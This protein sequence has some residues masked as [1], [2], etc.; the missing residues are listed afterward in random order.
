MPTGKRT[1]PSA[2]AQEISNILAHRAH[3]ARVTQAEL[4]KAADIS[5]SQLSKILR[6]DRQM[7]VDHLY[8]MCGA[9]GLKVR[10]VIREAEAVARARL[11]ASHGSGD[12]REPTALPFDLP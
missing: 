5:Q 11:S 3:A 6:G 12:E 9:L 10:D 2:V 1:K 4:A 8:A 7:D